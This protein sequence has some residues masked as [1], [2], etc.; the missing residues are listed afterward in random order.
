MIILKNKLIKVLLRENLIFFTVFEFIT[1]LCLLFLAGFDLERSTSWFQILYEQNKRTIPELEFVAMIW[2]IFAFCELYLA[3]S[4]NSQKWVTFY[5][6]MTIALI[7]SHIIYKL[8]FLHI[9]IYSADIVLFIL[10]TICQITLNVITVINRMH[11]NI[12]EQV[13]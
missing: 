8:I 12:L 11:H 5:R 9:E 6:T 2:I 3:I 4:T 13:R 7:P 10:F 1:I